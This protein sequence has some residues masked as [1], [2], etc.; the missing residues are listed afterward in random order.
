MKCIDY[1]SQPIGEHRLDFL[2]RNCLVAELKAVETLRSYLKARDER[3]GLLINFNV[4][5][6][7]K[8][9]RRIIWT[10]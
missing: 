9:V 10:P 4:P 2:V 1:R 5:L 8:G 3:L 7:L 6:L